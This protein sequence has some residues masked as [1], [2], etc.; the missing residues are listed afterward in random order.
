MI[1]GVI[2][3]LDGTLVDSEPLWQ[4]AEI[5]IFAKEGLQLTREDCMQT[6]GLQPYE[7][8]KHWYRKMIN[9]GKSVGD[10]TIELCESVFSL[11]AEKG[12]LKDGAREIL[13]FWYNKKIPVAIASASSVKLIEAVVQNFDLGKYFRV[14][15]SGDFE[16]YGKPHPGI[17][18]STAQHMKVDPVFTIVFEDSFNGM[19]AAKAARMK[20][21]AFLDDGGFNDTKYDFADL[22]LESF[23]NFGPAEYKFLES[24]M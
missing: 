7:A 13:E 17:F 5:N 20:L 10:L 16:N 6:K 21:V 1:E 4:E 12:R 3:D 24:L 11:F 9:P 14:L 15:Y 19:I 2:F 8:V 18:I 22:K 23:Y